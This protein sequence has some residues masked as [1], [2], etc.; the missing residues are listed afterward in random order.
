MA[1]LRSRWVMPLPRPLTHLKR[2]IS[3]RRT[4]MGC[5]A[6]SLPGST[7]SHANNAQTELQPAASRGLLRVFTSWRPDMPSPSN[8]WSGRRTGPTPSADSANTSTR[9]GSIFSRT[10]PRGR[11]RGSRR[12]CGRRSGRRRG[13]ARIASVSGISSPTKGAARRSWTSLPQRG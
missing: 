2:E 7:R 3:H 8:T 13:G 11:G 6:G 1:C 12:S 10:A 4:A 9:P 5:E